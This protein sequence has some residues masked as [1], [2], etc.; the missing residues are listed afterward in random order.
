VQ[1]EAVRPLWQTRPW[2]DSSLLGLPF[3]PPP[4]Q[5]FLSLSLGAE[6]CATRGLAEVDPTP[7]RGPCHGPHRLPYTR[8]VTRLLAGLFALFRQRRLDLQPLG[9]FAG[10]LSASLTV[11]AGAPQ[12]NKLAKSAPSRGRGTKHVKEISKH[13]DRSSIEQRSRARPFVCRC[14]ISGIL[15]AVCGSSFGCLVTAMSLAA[16]GPSAIDRASC[17]RPVS[18]VFRGCFAAVSRRPWRCR[19][20]RQQTAGSG[21][22]R[23][24]SR[25]PAPSTS[26]QLRFSLEK[27]HYR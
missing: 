11:K 9:E 15:L 6:D 8:R 24:R 10:L 13:V 5:R 27:W 12:L 1:R 17:S 19:G 3:P 2:P 18:A 26:T 23:R 4:R 22:C 14:P 21:T 20:R 25:N 7:R 16:Y